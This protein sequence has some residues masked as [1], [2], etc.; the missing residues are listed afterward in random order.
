MHVT[1]NNPALAWVAG[2]D[3]YRTAIGPLNLKGLIL[4]VIHIANRL[5][6]LRTG[7]G[8]G[9]HSFE[10]LPCT[11]GPPSQRAHGLIGCSG[12]PH[13]RFHCRARQAHWRPLH[14]QGWA[15]SGPRWRRAQR[16]VLRRCGGWLTIEG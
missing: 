8:V 7:L 15:T 14:C 11:S 16:P 6:L 5:L 10:L 9:H 13:G 3:H 1:W 4:A 2:I 12:P